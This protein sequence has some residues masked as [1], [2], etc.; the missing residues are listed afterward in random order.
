VERK[1]SRGEIWSFYKEFKQFMEFMSFLFQTYVEK[2]LGGENLF[3]EKMKNV[4]SD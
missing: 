3:G 2:N 4:R 1:L